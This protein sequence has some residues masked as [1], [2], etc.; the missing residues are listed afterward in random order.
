MPSSFAA[1]N[2]DMPPFDDEIFKEAAKRVFHNRAFNPDMLRDKKVRQLVM[3]TYEILRHAVNTH[4]P[5]DVPQEVTYALENNAFIFSA[6]KT[7]HSLREVGLSLVTDS[8]QIKPFD[9]FLSDVLKINQNYNHHYLRAEYQ[10]AVGSTQMAARWQ[11]IAKD[12]DRYDLQYRTAEDDHVRESHRLL[13]G[14]TLP[15]S[16][17]FWD[18]YFPPNGWGCRCTAVQVR[19]GKYP[20]TDPAFAMLKGDNCT[21]ANKQ[22]MFRFN[23]GKELKLYPPQHPYMP[24]NCG[25]CTAN[26]KLAYNPSSDKCQACGIIAKCMQQYTAPQFETIGTYKNGA[27]VRVSSAV[28][29]RESDDYK[30]ILSVATAFAKQGRKAD[31]LPRFDSPKNCDSYEQV[32]K[33]IAADYYGKCP[34]LAID[35]IYYE[36]EGYITKDPKK[37]L[38]N[39]LTHG[40]KQ[41][42]RLIIEKCD[43]QPWYIRKRI[44]DKIKEGV[45]VTEVW[46]HDNGNLQLFYKAGG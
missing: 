29:D 18:K 39:M 6:F 5:T 45:K 46:I 41:S 9:A 37:A 16:D 14:I 35:G 34:D 2:D 26:L 17:P 36:H 30:R 33:G 8:G 4:L 1:G 43:L 22:K 24:K 3:H 13:H 21:E 27:Q 23:P 42:D 28:K 20:L 19:K 12:G 11:Q 31:L 32:Y 44:D 25:G 10:H 40:L 15:Y 7:Y 38:H